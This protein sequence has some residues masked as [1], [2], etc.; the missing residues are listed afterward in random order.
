TNNSYQHELDLALGTYSD[1]FGDGIWNFGYRYYF[2]P[3]DISKGPYALNGTLAQTSNIG[4]QYSQMQVINDVDVYHVDATYV[5]NSK[6]F[7]GGIYA[8]TDNNSH[9]TIL[10]RSQDTYQLSLG[11]YFNDTSEVSI[12]YTNTNGSDSIEDTYNMN[13]PPIGY[14]YRTSFEDNSDT[15]GVKA[16][17]FIP[18][19]SFT[20][21]ELAGFWQYSKTDDLN[22]LSYYTGNADEV[23][24]ARYEGNTESHLV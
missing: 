24:H 21:I 6:W 16:R 22:T 5:F 2:T 13:Q 11:Y 19:Q 20:G 9:H 7:A 17:S 15:Y 3:V 12:Y 8:K 18:M 10:D 4:V 14:V 1:D 23:G